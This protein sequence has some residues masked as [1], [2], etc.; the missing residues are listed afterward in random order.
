ML[1][2]FVGPL[3]IVG[4]EVRAGAHSEGWMSCNAKTAG[5]KRSVDKLDVENEWNDEHA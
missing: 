2:G 4:L 1:R 5:T 3:G